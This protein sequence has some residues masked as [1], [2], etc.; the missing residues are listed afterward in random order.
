MSFRT[1]ELTRPSEIHIQSGQILIV[2][3][4]GTVSVSLDDISTIICQGPNIRISTMAIGKLAEKGITVLIFD[5]HYQPAA[6][7]NSYGT[8]SRRSRVMQ[9]QISLSEERIR[10]L[11]E[12]LIHAKIRNQ[13]EALHIL[14][15]NGNAAVAEYI[16]DGRYSVDVKESLAARDYFYFLDADLNRREESPLNSCLN[17]GY[18]VLRNRIIRSLIITGFLERVAENGV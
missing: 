12:M 10:Q 8:N 1:L 11:W 4:E 18:A 16:S 9:Q 13:S 6:V 7:V 15:K 5:E 14:G 17:Y 2:Q 3:E